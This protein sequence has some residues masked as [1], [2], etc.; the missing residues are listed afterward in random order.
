MAK[1]VKWFAWEV[2][3]KQQKE[4]QIEKATQRSESAIQSTLI[5]TVLPEYAGSLI[6]C[7]LQFS[8][9]KQLWWL[10][11]AICH[12]NGSF[13]RKMA[14]L[15]QPTLRNSM[16]GGGNT[17]ALKFHAHFFSLWH[18][19]CVDAACSKSSDNARPQRSVWSKLGGQFNKKQNTE[20]H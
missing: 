9:V 14:I 10:K 11:N 20:L 4:V 15:H 17:C 1:A 16:Y 13:L 18:F 12:W 19:S 2:I 7:A 6:V 8:T 3:G 5:K